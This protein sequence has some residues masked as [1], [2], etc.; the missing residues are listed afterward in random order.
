MIRTNG[1]THEVSGATLDTALME[2]EMWATRLREALQKGGGYSE[3][4]HKELHMEE[5]EAWLGNYAKGTIF[6]HV[7]L[8]VDDAFTRGFQRDLHFPQL[9]HQYTRYA[10]K[11]PPKQ[12]QP[13]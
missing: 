5:I 11:E 13:P 1:F 7:R 4:K 3:K 10:N 9:V 8:I 12:W 6:D 2:E